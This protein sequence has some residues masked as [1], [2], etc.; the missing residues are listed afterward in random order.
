M[1]ALYDYRGRTAFY[2]MRAILWYISGA[3]YGMKAV[4]SYHHALKRTRSKLPLEDFLLVIPFVY[5]AH[6]KMSK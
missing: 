6:N 5:V 4:L 2:I 1:T 3:F